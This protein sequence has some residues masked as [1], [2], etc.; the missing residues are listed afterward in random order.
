MKMIAINNFFTTYWS[1]LRYSAGQ[2]RL[3]IQNMINILHPP[4]ATGFPWLTLVSLLAIRL[5]FLEAPSLAVTILIVE[6]AQQV[7]YAAQTMLISIQQVPSS[8]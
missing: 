2:A 3:M 8:K 7:K 1:A 6:V 5:E 4:A